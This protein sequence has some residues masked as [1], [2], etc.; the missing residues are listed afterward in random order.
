ME[1]KN[2]NVLVCGLGMTGV[3]VVTFLL[4]KQANVSVHNVTEIDN[5]HV[6]EFRELGVK[7]FFGD[8][9]NDIVANYELI[10]V[11]PGIPSDLSFFKIAQQK[12]IPIVSEIE[13]A[14]M[15]CKGEIVGITGT[16]GKTTTTCLVD[17]I[18]GDK[19][20]HVQAVGNIGIP[21]ID[22]VD[23]STEDDI[24]VAELS[25]YQLETTYTL[26]PK[27]SVVLNITNDH[28]ERHKTLNNYIQAK[29]RVFVNQ[30]SED[31]TV[32]NYDNQYT[33]DMGQKT[34]GTVVWFSRKEQGL[35][36]SVYVKDDKIVTNFNGI[37][38]DV[39]FIKDIKMIGGHNVENV[40]ASVAIALCMSID[41]EQIERVVKNFN[42]VEHRIEYVRTLNGV[43]FYNDSKATNVEAAINAINAVNMN[44]RLIVGGDDKNL[45]LYDLVK[46]ASTKVSRLYII[47]SSTDN[48]VECC[49]KLGYKSFVTCDSLEEAVQLAYEE[50][51]VGECV[52]L[53]PG[54]AS[55]DMFDNF[56]HR[57]RV[58]K[59]SVLNIRG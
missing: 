45:P 38:E 32:L 42:G 1:L 2:K 52:M 5:N 27:C 50:A 36:K 55:F 25:S 11:S 22:K 35:E 41:I 23:D 46:C 3:N 34:N 16:N 53:S 43:T 17:K 37:E 48:F 8:S 26:K 33:R 24:F 18:L 29:E 15:F 12:N 31:Y 56:E 40:L 19:N 30:T 21:F 49:E 51:E 9:I 39:L 44:I 59:E 47:G 13:L 6:Q 57:G 20:E 10:V 28:L 4:K 54:C 14:N 58:F 7:V